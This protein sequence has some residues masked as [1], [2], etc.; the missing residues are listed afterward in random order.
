MKVA[1]A[2]QTTETPWS[3]GGVP[4]RGWLRN[5]KNR[6]PEIANRKS[7]ALEVARARGLC[8][9]TISSLYK[10]LEDLYTTF[11]YPLSHIWNCDESGMQ[12]GR[13]GGATVLAKVESKSVHII[14]PDQ[15]EAF[16]SII[17]HQCKWG[18][19]SKLLY[20]KGDIFH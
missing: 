1:Q 7:Q 14:E 16:V 3:A 19:N 13:K 15:R 11:K 18:E 5:F 2:T 10:N 6:H 17:L 20:P 8:Q 4:D 12:A 9:C